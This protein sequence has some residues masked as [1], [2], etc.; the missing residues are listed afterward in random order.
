MTDVD[1]ILRDFS[2]QWRSQQP[3]VDADFGALPAPH[4]GRRRPVAM[5][6]LAVGVA[7]IMTVAV[8]AWPRSRSQRVQ[9][10]SPTTVKTAKPENSGPR[11]VRTIDL[12]Q[13]EQ[14]PA[15]IDVAPGFVSVLALPSGRDHAWVTTF[16]VG[17][18]TTTGAVTSQVRIPD[19]GPIALVGDAH[20]QWVSS[21]FKQNAHVFRI[22]HGAITATLTTKGDAALALTATT[23]WVLQG[24]ELV[25][26]DPRTANVV[27]RLALPSADRG[28][29][30]RF[31]SVGPLGVWLANPYDGSIWHVS[32][33]DRTVQRVT[34][35]RTY[36]SRL[37]QLAQHLWVATTNVITAID[38]KTGHTTRVIDLQRRVIDLANDGHFLW[39]ATDGP[40]LYR[41]DPSTGATTSVALPAAGPILA[42]ASDLNSRTIWALTAG[43]QS[44]AG[45]CHNDCPNLLQI[46]S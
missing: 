27:A 8:L 28:Y 13:E 20:T 17:Q 9:V 3:V 12:G 39:V 45:L 1:E 23:L 10:V 24:G 25:R 2:R 34:S 30:P 43:T 33:D 29:G 32:T 6:L 42:L 36:A 4:G 7:A 46:K 40:R 5:V 16:Y 14:F 21:D 26:V 41:I 22:E 19:D 44:G 11:V 18:G 31:I 38:P 35:V 37:T 15:A